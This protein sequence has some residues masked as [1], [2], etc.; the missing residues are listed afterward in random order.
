MRSIELTTVPEL[1]VVSAYS[2][3]NQ[4][5]PFA[6]LA[7]SSTNGWYVIG[8]FFLPVSMPA[9]L[10]VVGLVTDSDEI[11]MSVRVFDMVALESKLLVNIA[12][13]S[14]Q[15]AVSGKVTL[16]G[17]RLYQFQARAL[18]ESGNGLVQSAQLI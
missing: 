9:R 13:E 7:P 4:N 3:Q 11:T 1:V 14:A 10:E 8:T 18:G 5:V 16:A 12:S 6:D 2:T 15:R 17:N